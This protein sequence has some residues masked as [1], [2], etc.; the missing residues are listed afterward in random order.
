MRPTQGPHNMGLP[1]NQR[2]RSKTNKLYYYQGYHDG[3]SK[4]KKKPPKGMYINHDDVVKLA[5]QDLKAKQTPPIMNRNDDFLMETEHEIAV[6]YGQVRL[7][8]CRLFDNTI[9]TNSFL[10][11]YSPPHSLNEKIQKNKQK[12]SSLKAVN[13]KNQDGRMPEEIALNR[14]NPRW[15]KDD[16]SLGTICFRRFGQNFKVFF[17]DFSR[18]IFE[19]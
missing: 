9:F 14:V 12:I 5:A 17:C 7:D 6:L 15:S 13:E 4:Y 8:I 11:F 18:E 19:F 16:I 1:I 3:S 10:F 2:P